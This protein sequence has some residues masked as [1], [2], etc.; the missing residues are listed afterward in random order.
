MLILFF[1]L[2]YQVLQRSYLFQMLSGIRTDTISFFFSAAFSSQGKDRPCHTMRKQYGLLSV[3]L[4]Y[5]PHV[6]PLMQMIFMSG[7]PSLL[8]TRQ[9]VQTPSSH[10][11]SPVLQ[12]APSPQY[13]AFDT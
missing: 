9:K 11:H 6:F 3:R 12:T 4:L 5:C 1:I 7:S 8:F 13:Q 2:Y 10:R